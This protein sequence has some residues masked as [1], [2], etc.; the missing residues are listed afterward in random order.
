MGSLFSGVLNSHHSTF[1]ARRLRAG[2]AHIAL[3]ER[4]LD[5]ARGRPATASGMAIGVIA[6]GIL[7]IRLVRDQSAAARG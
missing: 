7:Q 5:R 1:T 2:L 3:I 6:G 4:L